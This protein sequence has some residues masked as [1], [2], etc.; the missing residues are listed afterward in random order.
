MP[1][2]RITAAR[3]KALTDLLQGLSGSAS[4]LSAQANRFRSLA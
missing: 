2:G 1:L 3:I 4:R